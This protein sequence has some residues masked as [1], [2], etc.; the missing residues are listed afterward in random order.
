MAA[1]IALAERAAGRTGIN[2]AVGCVIVKDGRIAG[3]GWTQDG[4]RPHAEAMALAQAGALTAGADV[5]VTLEPC[6]HENGRGPSCAASLVLARPARVVI[7]CRD[8]DP[9]TDGR[10]ITRLKDAGITAEA[11]VLANEAKRGLAGFFSRVE[12]GRPYVT[13]KLAT[14][15][16]GAIALAS[17]ES[18]WIT[19]DAARAHA[20]LERARC[21]AILVGAGTVRADRPALGVRLAGLEDRSPR[22]VMLGSGTAPDGWEVIRNVQEIPSLNCNHLLVE[23]GAQTAASVL[24]AG[25]AD[26]LLLYRAPILIGGGKACLDDIGLSRLSDAHGL[27]QLQDRRMF[28]KDQMEIYSRS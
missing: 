21:D 3:R 16:D 23:G 2:P 24:R 4:G 26:R 10:G 1:A 27:W 12:R 14:S 9:R 28:G 20:H 6:A 19:G 11:G 17:G 13:I 18:R 8:P 22:R 25:M 7:A 5:Y 15:L